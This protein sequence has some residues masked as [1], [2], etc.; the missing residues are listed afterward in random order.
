M[1]IRNHGGTSSVTAATSSHRKYIRHAT[2]LESFLQWCANAGV[3]PPLLR[4]NECIRTNAPGKRESNK[5]VGVKDMGQCIIV[6]DHTTDETIKFNDSKR[7]TLTHEQ[8]T[9]IWKRQQQAKRVREDKRQAAVRNLLCIWQKLEPCTASRYTTDKRIETHGCRYD[10]NTRS[11]VVPLRD[12]DGELQSFQYLYDDKSQ[13]KRFAKGTSTK[14]V[15][16]LMGDITE[17]VLLC[18]G[19]ATGATLREQTGKTVACCMTVTNLQ[20]VARAI[21]DR[22]PSVYITICGDDDRQTLGNPGRTRAYEVAREL[23]ASLAMPELCSGCNC[24]DFNDQANCVR[25]GAGA[26]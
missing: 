7:S 24:S 22:Y 4:L 6:R 16:F 25:R 5:S 18:E 13:P 19:L 10:S 23:R 1:S 20:N 8:W 11:L 15:F 12:I 14:G 2:A 3:R 21:R 9:A 26:E 17:S